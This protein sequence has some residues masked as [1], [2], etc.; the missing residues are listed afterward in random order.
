MK[1][2]VGAS[3]SHESARGH[4][5]GSAKY[6]DDLW[7]TLANVVHLWPVLVPHA[8]ARVLGIDGIPDNPASFLM[9]MNR[10]ARQVNFLRAM[11]GSM[12]S[13]ITDTATSALSNGGMGRT[14]SMFGKK[15]ITHANGLNDPE[16][17]AILV[18]AENSLVM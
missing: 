14:L 9:Y 3:L 1:R 13:S 7:P 8:R 10:T 17:R 6:V 18:G 12:L 4:V 11:G 5:T 2:Q 15:L 16:L